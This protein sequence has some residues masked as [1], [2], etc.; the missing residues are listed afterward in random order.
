MG[1][2]YSD[3][4]Y[5]TGESGC[6]THWLPN[7]VLA[8]ESWLRD[9]VTDQRFWDGKCDT[10][11]TGEYPLEPMTADEQKTFWD[12]FSSMPSILAGK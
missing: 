10:T 6:M 3:I 7:S 2:M 11:H 9:K 4:E 1:D 12:N 8:M 5:I